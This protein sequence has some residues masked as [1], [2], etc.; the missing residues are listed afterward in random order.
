MSVSSKQR[1]F[2][3]VELMVGLVVG[4]LV[5]GIIIATFMQSR[6]N[7]NQDEEIAKMQENGRFVLS[8]LSR[9]LSMAGF[10]GSMQINDT[11]TNPLTA[12]TCATALTWNDINTSIQVLDYNDAIVTSCLGTLPNAG[13]RVLIVKHTDGKNAEAITSGLDTSRVF[14]VTNG[15]GG[16]Y[17]V[18]T[19]T[20]AQTAMTANPNEQY[21]EYQTRM[22][23]VRDDANGVPTIYRK[24][25]EVTGGTVTMGAEQ[26]LVTGLV[27]VGIYY[28]VDNAGYDNLGN[29]TTGTRD[30]VADLYTSSPASLAEVVSARIDVLMRST[31][32]DQTYTNNKT[33]FVGT[34]TVT[35]LAGSK[36]YGRV[37]TNTVHL[38]NVAYRLQMENM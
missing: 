9:E 11:I 5:T 24:D 6:R 18:S 37:F 31:N 3:L 34:T 19:A 27:Q 25:L 20:A 12:D 8:T 14:F 35:S 36:Y 28:G 38:R 2:T 13:S 30:G 10:L 7:Y 17:Q 26:A 1:G 32:E 33:Y 23:F 22:Y 16:A 21:W 15:R 29:F 4:L